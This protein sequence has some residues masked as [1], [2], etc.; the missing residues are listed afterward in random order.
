MIILFRELQKTQYSKGG[1]EIY[2]VEGLSVCV[3]IFQIRPFDIEP[4]Q[5][6]EY[7]FVLLR[8]HLGTPYVDNSSSQEVIKHCAVEST[9]SSFGNAWNQLT[10]LHEKGLKAHLHHHEW[11]YGNSWLPLRELHGVREIR[12]RFQIAL[13]SVPK[14][15]LWNELL[16]ES[17]GNN[18][19]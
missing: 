6:I 4:S 3:Q 12:H 14:N 1:Y 10:M 19:A 7:L 8:R 2:L 16:L 11:I 18:K 13:T 9:F 17:G 15:I 5:G